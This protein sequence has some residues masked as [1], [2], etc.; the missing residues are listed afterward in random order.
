VALVR[1]VNGGRA[2]LVTRYEDVRR[3]LIDPVFSRAALRRPEATVLVEGARIPYILTNMDTPEHTRVRRLV[4]RAFTTRGVEPIRPRAREITDALIDE[5][6]ATG[7]PVDFV[8]A[9]A[10]P[11]PARI[12]CELLGVPYED[13]DRVHDWLDVTMSAGVR[14]AEEVAATFEQIMGYLRGLIAGK[15]DTPAD[16]LISALIAAHD[17]GDRLSE[18]EMLYTVF[19]LIAGGF[20]TTIRLLTNSVLILNE[21]PDQLARLRAEPTLIIDALDEL[22]RYIPV[23]VATMERVTLTD[24]ELSGVTIPAGST[25]IPSLHS[26]NR[27]AALLADPDRFDVAR[28]PAPH[29]TFGH[30]I[31]RCIGAPLARL[32][33]EVAYLALLRR[34]PGLRPAAPPES[35]DWKT[36]VTTVGP[37][38]LPVTW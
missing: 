37:S 22:L 4:A 11:L 21:H 23:A 25:V 2:Y 24:V 7:P 29:L 13:R 9:F 20:E 33:L 5:M 30:G 1:L 12:I 32:E 26:A 17:E 36:G 16:D 10:S 8:T 38:A 31:H 3:V 34:L 18:E 14:S 15:R 6:I 35:L 19:I 28:P 27:D